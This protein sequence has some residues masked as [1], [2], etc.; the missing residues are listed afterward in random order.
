MDNGAAIEK[1]ETAKLLGVTIS[2]DLKWDSHVDE[3]CARAAR[4]LY[5]IVSLRTIGVPPTA[6]K[7][8]YLCTIRSLLTYAVPAWCNIGK[9]LTDKLEKVERR[10]TRIIATPRISPTLKEAIN[11]TCMRLMRQVEK[12]PHHPL[13]VTVV[14]NPTDC[15]LRRKNTVSSYWAKTSRL[16]DSFTSFADKL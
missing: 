8:L 12:H 4:R 3:I 16:R 14:W 10:A 6:L 11:C 15:K 1:V 7:Q 2:G 9:G 5:S 13:A